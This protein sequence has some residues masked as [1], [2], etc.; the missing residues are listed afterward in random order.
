ME[1][2]NTSMFQNIVIQWNPLLTID[3]IYLV[4]T[5]VN[6]QELVKLC[7]FSIPIIKQEF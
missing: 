5:Q 4:E 2:Q 7:L 1:V 6:S 3:D